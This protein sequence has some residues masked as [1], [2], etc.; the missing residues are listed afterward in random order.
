ML[1]ARSTI[2]ALFRLGAVP[3]V[4]ENDTVA[5]EEIRYGDND[6][7]AARVAQMI[8][9]GVLVLLSDVDGLYDA[10]PRRNTAARRLT[11]V[12]AITAEIEAMAGGTAAGGVGSGGM[13]TKLEAARIAAAGDCA[14]IVTLGDR[15]HP[16]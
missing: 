1:N 9:A 15:P 14:T 11:R 8:G 3:V 6:R 10:D 7:L 16:L 5:T 2:E 12:T 4:N 13:R